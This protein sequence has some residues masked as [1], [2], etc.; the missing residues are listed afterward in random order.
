MTSHNDVRFMLGQIMHHVDET[1]TEGRKIIRP[2]DL[3]KLR[4]MENDLQD[5]DC[6]LEADEDTNPG[7]TP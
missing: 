6:N 4:L 5:I 2:V 7:P 3:E 1:I